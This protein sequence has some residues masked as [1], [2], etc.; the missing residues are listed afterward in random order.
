MA[1]I[2][3][4]QAK[5]G[6]KTYRVRVRRKGQPVQTA[7]FPSLKDA[8]QWAVMIEGEIIAGKHCPTRKRTHTALHYWTGIYRK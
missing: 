4:H 8:R 5:D 6:T 2:T 7:S 3:V 1:A